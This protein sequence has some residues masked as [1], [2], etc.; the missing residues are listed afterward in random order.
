MQELEPDSAIDDSEFQ[1][2][3]PLPEWD[4]TKDVPFDRS[5]NRY[6]AVYVRLLSAQRYEYSRENA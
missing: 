1:F 3:T 2:V 4:D 6:G 5:L